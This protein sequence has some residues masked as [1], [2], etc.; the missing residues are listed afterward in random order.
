MHE[1]HKI[2]VENAERIGMILNDAGT[3]KTKKFVERNSALSIFKRLLIEIKCLFCRHDNGIKIG[4]GR[5]RKCLDRRTG[6]HV[7][8]I[9]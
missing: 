9:R 7:N 6:A 5:C 8:R 3:K 4:A 2:T 1:I